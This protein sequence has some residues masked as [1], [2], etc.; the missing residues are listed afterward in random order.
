[1]PK[2]IRVSARRPTNRAGIIKT[3]EKELMVLLRD[4]SATG[5]RLRLAKPYDVPDRFTL[6]AAMEK[7]N[8]ECVV[9]WRRGNDLGV[10]FE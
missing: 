1:M 5:A 7:I 10:R 8:A 6:V 9:I 2:D 4:A 3:G